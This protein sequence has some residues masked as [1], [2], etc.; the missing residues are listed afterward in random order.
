MAGWVGLQE[1][2]EIS[3]KG[4]NQDVEEGGGG[5]GILPVGTTGSVAPG[6]KCRWQLR[7]TGACVSPYLSGQTLTGMTA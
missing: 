3:V 1:I 6:R 7:A 2:V 4:V 5:K